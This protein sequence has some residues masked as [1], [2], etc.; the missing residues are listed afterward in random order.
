MIGDRSVTE[1]KHQRAYEL[2]KQGCSVR[3]IT[4]RIDLSPRAVE[5]AIEKKRKEEAALKAE[6][7]SAA[8]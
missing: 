6:P 8:G 2:W 5:R 4:Q 3:Q 1:Q 7:A